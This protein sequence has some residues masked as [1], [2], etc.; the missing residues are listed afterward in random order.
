MYQIYNNPTKFPLSQGTVVRKARHHHDKIMKTTIKKTN[1]AIDDRKPSHFPLRFSTHTRKVAEKD[2]KREN[3]RIV[4]SLLRARSDSSIRSLVQN[5]TSSMARERFF[6][7]HRRRKWSSYRS[8]IHKQNTEM[9]K[10]IKNAK[11]S[12]IRDKHE[13][14]RRKRYLQNRQRARENDI[15]AIPQHAKKNHSHH[16]SP[17]GVKLPPIHPNAHSKSQPILQTIKDKDG[18]EKSTKTSKKRIKS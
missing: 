3:K 18:T 6:D 11:P 7:Q 17:K 10:R 8:E 9:Y 12:I 13:M 15:F 4:N 1:S 2:I 5:K 14:E 16:K